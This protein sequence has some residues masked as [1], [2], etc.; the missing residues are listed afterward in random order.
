[1][2][3]LILTDFDNKQKN[4]TSN[5]NEFNKR[6]NKRFDKDLIN[7]FITLNGAKYFSSGIFQNYLVCIPAK[8]YIKY[9]SN[10]TRIDS[11][12]SNGMPEENTENITNSD[13]NFVPTFLDHHLLPD[14]NF[15]RHCLIN[16]IYISKKV[17]NIYISYTLIPWLRNLNIDFT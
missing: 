2:I 14:L 16:N 7:K 8:K 5:K 6:I 13:R 10:I 3:L 15:N 4:V 9:F 12:K 17:I 11:W 1:M